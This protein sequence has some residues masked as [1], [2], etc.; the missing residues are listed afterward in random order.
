MKLKVLLSRLSFAE[1]SNLSLGNE[2]QG[3]IKEEDVPKL[4]THVNDGLVRIYSRF[5]LCT[6]QLLIEQVQ[7]ITN[8]HLITKYAESAGAD[9]RWPY[10]KDL[11]GNLFTG[12]VIRILEVHDIVGREYVLNDKDDPTSLF[13]PA[14]QILQ[15]PHPKAG[16]GLAVLYQARH[17]YIENDDLEQEIVI[18]F[19]LEGA[20]QAF[21]AYKV[22]S[23]M[24]GQE[25]QV[26]SQEHLNTYDGICTDVEERDLV[27]V[28]FATS[29][30]KLENRGF[31]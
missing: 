4:V 24:N 5:V 30:H 1:L 11:P 19:V 18:P 3:I 22:F 13:T 7:H 26:K 15:V 8:Y 12:D 27:N 21:V 17:D 16:K 14:P 25:N 20:L 31:V 9:V 23:H 29:H 6:K 10:I 2:G 28:T